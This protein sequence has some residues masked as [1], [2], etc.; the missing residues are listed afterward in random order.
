MFFDLRW[1]YSKKT[2][3]SSF[4][5]ENNFKP[6]LTKQ[7]LNI[8]KL[9]FERGIRF[10]CRI[11]RLL[12]ARRSQWW[13]R[14]ECKLCFLNY[15]A[16]AWSSRRS[17]ENHQF[18]GFT[19]TFIFEAGCIRSENNVKKGLKIQGLVHSTHHGCFLL[20][21]CSIHFAKYHRYFSS[22]RLDAQNLIDGTVLF[23][24]VSE[25]TNLLNENF[26]FSENVIQL[27]R[28]GMCP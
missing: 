19:F 23:W 6:C 28:Q 11:A 5:K 8:F 4:Y 24:H 16:M 22:R 7:L 17:Y 13:R 14:V 10:L 26:L 2:S 27:L 21:Y 9:W 12:A 15:C 18:C 20:V 25:N 3:V 1:I